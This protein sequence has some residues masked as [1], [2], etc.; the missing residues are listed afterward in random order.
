MQTWS[1]VAAAVRGRV[2]SAAAAK[3]CY[4]SASAGK[5]LVPRT[6]PE[7]PDHQESR[8]TPIFSEQT[9][10]EAAKV[11]VAKML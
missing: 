11:R 5:H 6:G 9:R 10:V 1:V 4:R 8:R 7:P 2:R 3:T